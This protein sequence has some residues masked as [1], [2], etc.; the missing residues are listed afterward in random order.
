MSWR[1]IESTVSGQVRRAVRPVPITQ[2]TVTFAEKRPKKSWLQVY[3]GEQEVPGAYIHVSTTLHYTGVPYQAHV[4]AA[5]A[6]GDA[7]SNVIAVE[8]PHGPD[9]PLLMPKG[10]VKRDFLYSLG[11]IGAIGDGD[12]ANAAVFPSAPPPPTSARWWAV[13]DA[14]PPL[15]ITH[16]FPINVVVLTPLTENRRRRGEARRHSLEVDNTDAE[17]QLILGVCA[18]SVAWSPMTSRSATSAFS[19]SGR[20]VGAAVRG[21]RPA[22]YGSNADHKN[23]SRLPARLHSRVARMQTSGT[24]C[25]VAMFLHV[26]VHAG[27]GAGGAG[28]APLVGAC[29]HRGDWRV[30]PLPLSFCKSSLMRML[31][32]CYSAQGRC[33]WK[34]EATVPDKYIF[35]DTSILLR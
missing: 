14:W 5:K 31:Y 30:R 26:F 34:N 11:R 10:D 1:D 35:Y 17:G 25:T 29:R 27:A 19:S 32:S 28:A 13:S 12:I 9:P 18:C 2:I 3:V 22:T 24:G 33:E 7:L 15:A 16:T 6:G 23:V 4:S 20:A 8:G 21:V